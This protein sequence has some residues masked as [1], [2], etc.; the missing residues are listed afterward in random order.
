MLLSFS[1]IR[2]RR[3]SRSLVKMRHCPVS[4]LWKFL[5]LNRG[6]IRLGYNKARLRTSRWA[7]RHT[8]QL[9]I[10]SASPKLLLEYGSM[11]EALFPAHRARLFRRHHRQCN[12][13]ECCCPYLSPPIDRS[14]VPLDQNTISFTHLPPT[15][16]LN[17]H[18]FRVRLI[19]LGGTDFPTL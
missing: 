5:L 19:E 6:L 7:Y 9:K 11:S 10:F 14:R 8:P 2:E 1:L 3:E 17:F 4:K 15:S 13:Q 16:P 18:T 12:E